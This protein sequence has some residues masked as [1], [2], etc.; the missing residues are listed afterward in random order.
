ME[1]EEEETE[2]LHAAQKMTPAKKIPEQVRL[3]A[4]TPPP[5]NQISKLSFFA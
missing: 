2:L 5:P 3:I 1:K 4:N